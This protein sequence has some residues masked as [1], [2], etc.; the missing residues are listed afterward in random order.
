MSTLPLIPAWVRRRRVW[1]VSSQ[2]ITSALAR[3]ATARG[4]RS[5]RL[6]IGVATITSVPCPMASAIPHLQRVPQVQ[7]PPLEGPCLGFDYAT[8]LQAGK[9]EPG[10]RHASRGHDPHLR[11]AEGHV[12][13]ELHSNRVYPPGGA[14]QERSFDALAT[15]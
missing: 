5:W 1:R 13:W 4:D 8:G 12:N 15:E 7:V 10:G 6:P 14:K 2:A 3:A 11:A 9:A